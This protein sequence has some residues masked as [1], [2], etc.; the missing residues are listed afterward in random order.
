[1]VLNLSQRSRNITI[2]FAAWLSVIASAFLTALQLWLSG[3]ASLGIVM[4]VMLG[5]HALIG[6]GEALITIAA[7]GFIT[8]TRPDI[9]KTDESPAGKSWIAAGLVLSLFVLLL[10]PFASTSPD[11]LERVAIDLGF[12]NSAANAPFNVLPDY[13]VQALGSSSLSTLVAGF[14]GVAAVILVAVAI[15]SVLRKRGQR[16]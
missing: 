15:A 12:I 11:G 16:G 10:A 8:R 1:M 2:G 13:T 4:P 5:V 3:I 9:L 7:V 6:I 14:I